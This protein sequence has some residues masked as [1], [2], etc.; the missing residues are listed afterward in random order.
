MGRSIHSSC[1][2]KHNDILLQGTV[3]LSPREELPTGA[4]QSSMSSY[5]HTETSD[6]ILQRA[7]CRRNADNSDI[8]SSLQAGVAVGTY[9]LKS[10]FWFV[11]NWCSV[12]S[13]GTLRCP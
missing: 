5:R 2:G 13:L 12:L 3:A 7:C 8:I 1:K 6:N 4:A 10:S 9:I 11:Q